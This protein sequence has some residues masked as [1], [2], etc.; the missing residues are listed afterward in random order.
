MGLLNSEE[1]SH[2]I[3]L[4][5]KGLNDGEIQEIVKAIEREIQI[6][7]YDRI[8]EQMKIRSVA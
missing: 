3:K 6:T 7:V 1:V 8:R 4:Y 5:L 2:I